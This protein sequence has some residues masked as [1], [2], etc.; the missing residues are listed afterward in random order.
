[1]S[2]VTVI[3][4]LPQR[5]AA[6]SNKIAANLKE[7]SHC[8]F[9]FELSTRQTADLLSLL[10]LEFSADMHKELKAQSADKA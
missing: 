6:I 2:V 3:T 4:A 7:V 5:N 9:P 10:H 8:F 1:M